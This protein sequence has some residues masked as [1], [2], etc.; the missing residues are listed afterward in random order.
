MSR[1]Q[2]AVLLCGVSLLCYDIITGHDDHSHDIRMGR[3]PEDFAFGVSTSAYQTEGAWDV[4]GKGESIWDV[5]THEEG[6]VTDGANAND[7]AKS[8]DMYSEDVQLLVNLGVTHYRFSISWSRVMSDGTN[9]TLNQAGLK[10]YSDVI[11][12]LLK[13][14]IQPVVTLYHWDLPQGLQDTGGWLSDSIIHRFRDYADVCFRTYG[15]RVQHWITFNEPFITSWMGY[16][17]GEHAPGVQQDNATYLVAHNIIR[18]HVATYRLYQDKYRV[19]Q[20][21]L[22]GITLGSE[23]YEPKS[24]G[25]PDLEAADRALSFHLGLF[26][27][28]LF[29]GDYPETVK[30]I[31]QRKADRLGSV[32]FL[33]V[34]HHTTKLVSSRGNDVSAR[35]GFYRELAVELD[36]DYTYPSLVYREDMDPKGGEQRLMGFGMRKLLNYIRTTYNNPKVY[37]TENGFADCGTMK[38]QKRIMYLREYSN[39]VLQAIQ[40]GCEV[41]GYFVRSLLD[42]F[43]WTSGYEPKRGLYYVDFGRG[44]RPRYPK[45]SA[46]FYSLLIKEH[47]FT[48][49]VRDFRAYPA[50]RDEFL[51]DHF[52]DDFMWGTATSAYQVEGAWNEDGKGPSIWDTFAH[53]TNRIADGQTGDVACDSYHKIDEDV[54]M[55]KDLG[56]QHYRFSIAWSRVLPDGTPHSLNMLG[57]QYYNNLI[58]ALLAAN[59]QPMVTLYHWDLPQALQDMGGWMDSAIID[60]FDNYARVCFEQFGD[61]V[62]LWITF[63]EAF[64]VAWLGHGIGIFAPGITEPGVGVYTVA[65]NIIRSHSRAYHTYRRHFQPL[66]NGKVGIS[67]DIEWKEPLTLSQQD[68]Y[69][70]DRAIMFKLGWFGNPIYGSGDYPE[71]MK[72]YVGEKSRRQGYTQSRLPAFTEEEKRMNKGSY[73]FLGLNHYT[74]NVINYQ[75]NPDSGVHYEEDQDMRSRFDPCWQQSEASWL[76][77]NSWGLRYVLNFIKDRFG[78]PPLYITESGRPDSGGKDDINRIYYYRNYTN[79]VL[80]AIKLDGCNVKG[81]TAWSLMDN[82]EW[83]EGYHQQFG[84]YHV[85]FNDPNR[86][87]TP[88]QSADFYRHLISE[89]GYTMNSRVMTDF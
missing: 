87:R 75:P 66:Y 48:P 67:L 43:E 81:Y 42:S 65:H 83:L 16:E 80:K 26:A 9:S 55:L 36:V 69:A 2:R 72:R 84:L 1:L 71:V 25:Q 53:E 38:D 27:D 3:F 89:N 30:T 18:S 58:D 8:Y 54:Q 49:H 68:H 21:G 12:E 45:A 64:V 62:P 28:P 33:G 70:A 22:V 56:V 52:P 41:K 20:R 73:D 60:H 10:H 82:F 63:N 74:T 51:Y 34:N 13:H 37:I 77:S 47:G 50:D 85:D 15:D 14:N 44:E 29:K 31:L 11:D 40:D 4:D 79:E 61:R 59:I 23:W 57:V 5:F 35:F 76:W 46:H 24:E 17:T 19:T 7:A 39:N 32:D 78:N 6:H 88:K 86:T